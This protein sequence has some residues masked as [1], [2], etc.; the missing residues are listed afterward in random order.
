MSS[1]SLAALAALFGVLA[2]IRPTPSMAGGHETV[3][4]GFRAGKDGAS[5]QAG[6][7]KD[8]AGNLYGTAGTWGADEFGDVFELTPDGKGGWSFKPLYALTGG[9]DGAFPEAPV[10]FD[11]KGNLYGTTIFGGNSSKGAVFEISPDR[12]GHWFL[13]GTYDF[14]GGNDGGQPGSGV[15]VD[16]AGNVFG[17]AGAGRLASG[18]VFELTPSRNGWKESVLHAF[19]GGKDGAAPI[20]TL[21]FGPGG[22]LYGTASGGGANQLGVVFRL[23]NDGT[24]WHETVLH[25]FQGG[26]DGRQP[27]SGVTFDRAG[28]LYGTTAYPTGS[29]F[30]L[31]RPANV[32][33]PGQAWPLTSLYQFTGGADGGIPFGGVTFDRAGSL[34][35]ATVFGGLAQ[36]PNGQPCGVIYRLVP[37]QSGAW[38]ETV[39]HQFTGRRDGGNS[40]ATL[41]FDAGGK[42]YGTAYDGG[43]RGAGV[44]FD[45]GK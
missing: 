41:V 30:E 22:D 34:F 40:Y 32:N 36:C 45:V 23:H 21:S 16:A 27:E 29:V 6:L 31:A 17:T 28:N 15:V 20:S 2:A 10:A 7:I 13:A 25:A 35:G 18:V 12:H 3:L 24:H 4:H 19:T 42:L 26:Q 43:P 38:T 11:T 37:A 8:V 44:V 5:P 14:T 33:A 1:K 39:L 9:E